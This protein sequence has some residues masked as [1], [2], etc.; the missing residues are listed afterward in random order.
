MKKFAIAAAAALCSAVFSTATP[1]VADTVTHFGDGVGGSSVSDLLNQV[2]IGSSNIGAE[3]NATTF[4]VPGEAGT[5]TDLTFSFVQDTGAFQFEFGFI[6]MNDTLRQ[7][8]SVSQKLWWW[9]V[10]LQYSS[11]TS[12]FNDRI[13]DPGAISTTY[14]V[15]AGTEL[16]FF[17]LPNNTIG[18]LDDLVDEALANAFDPNASLDDT[19]R[20]PLF[21]LSDAN[22]GEFDQMLSFIDNGVTLFTFEDLTRARSDSDED[23]TDLAF[24]IDVELEV[25]DGTRLSGPPVT[26]SPPTTETP[27][28]VPEPPAVL[29][30]LGLGVGAGLM[31]K[32]KQQ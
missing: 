13:H 29:S 15:D 6:E 27:Q 9:T 23:F 22:E 16:L 5:T 2:G 19:L 8:D 20:S 17:L 14:S 11:P 24:L 10:A 12:V 18:N 3:T 26:T 25:P 4:F 31:L 7:T 1:A 28:S 32:R 30:L 21:S